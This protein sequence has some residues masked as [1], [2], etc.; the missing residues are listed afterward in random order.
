MTPNTKNISP[1][2]NTVR[3]KLRSYESFLFFCLNTF[4][5]IKKAKRI[6]RI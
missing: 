5:N 4:G 1:L 3:R 2:S 6:P